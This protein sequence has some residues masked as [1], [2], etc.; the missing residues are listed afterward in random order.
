MMKNK[1]M[2]IAVVTMMTVGLGVVGANG[3]FTESRA[4][5]DKT[6]ISANP[7]V[8]SKTYDID[9]DYENGKKVY[10]VEFDSAGYEYDYT[11]DAETKEI[12]YSH[13]EVDDDYVGKAETAVSEDIGREEAVRIALAKAGLTE[14]Q[15]TRLRVERDIDDGRV[16]YEVEFI[17]EQKEYEY[18]IDG[19]S[20]NI[21]DYEIERED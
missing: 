6:A 8:D 16:E 3:M 12:L 7:G 19:A 1:K 14:S 11:I 13:K 17:A 5:E 15:V 9:M 18:E 21:L 10:E 2:I 20:G 4:A